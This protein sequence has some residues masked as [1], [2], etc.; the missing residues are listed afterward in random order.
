M[1]S[2]AERVPNLTSVQPPPP[3]SPLLKYMQA[4]GFYVPESA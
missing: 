1:C 2:A 4:A 3:L